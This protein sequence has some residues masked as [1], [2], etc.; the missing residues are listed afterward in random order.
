[1]TGY[2][3]RGVSSDQVTAHYRAEATEVA[4]DAQALVQPVVTPRRGDAFVPFS[5][6][7][8]QD[9]AGGTLTVA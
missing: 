8:E 7:I 3:W 2:E 1:V 4:D 9:W 5:I 6:E